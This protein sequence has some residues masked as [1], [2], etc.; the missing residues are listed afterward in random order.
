MN[1]IPLLAAVFSWAPL[2]AA[3]ADV[4][5]ERRARALDAATRART[6]ATPPAGGG[7][8]VR[9]DLSALPKGARVDRALVI[10]LAKPDGFPLA[11]PLAGQGPC[12]A[13]GG[14][15]GPACRGG[16]HGPAGPRFIAFD[17]SDVVAA[18]E[19]RQAGQ[20]RAVGPRSGGRGTARNVPGNHL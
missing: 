8:V 14:E 16:G 13:A 20:P 5:T 11:E 1:R 19:C 3:C 10:P 12:A 4:V 7:S 6:H 2:C 18:L 9:F 17:A 15:V